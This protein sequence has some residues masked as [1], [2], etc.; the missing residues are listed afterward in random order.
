ML[1][2][3]RFGGGR[4]RKEVLQIDT[5][6]CAVIGDAGM[7]AKREAKRWRANTANGGEIGSISGPTWH[8]HRTFENL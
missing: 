6:T 8:N 7:E 5:M 3:G 4:R 2:S 1:A